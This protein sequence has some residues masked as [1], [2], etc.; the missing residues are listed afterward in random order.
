MSDQITLDDLDIIWMEDGLPMFYGDRDDIFDVVES[1]G[2]NIY[3]VLSNHTKLLPTSSNS[4]STTPADKSAPPPTKTSLTL[5][6]VV[7]NFVGRSVSISDAP[8]P[9]SEFLSVEESC[10]YNMPAIPHLLIEKLDQFFRLVDAQHGTESIVMLTYDLNKQ[11]PEGWG[12]LVPDQTNT[13]VH[14][15]YDPH[16][17]AE[18]KPDH[19]MIVGS[20]HSHPGM[21][22]YASGTDH[23]DQ[24]DFDGI[25]ITFGW[26]KSVNN[27]AT[28]YHIE[29]QMAGQAYTLK[30]ED[31]FEDYIIDKAP[32]PQVVEWSAKVK[33][34]LPPSMGGHHPTTLGQVPQA[35][36]KKAFTEPGTKYS[37]F[38]NKDYVQYPKHILDIIDDSS[39]DK[40]SIIICEANYAQERD[41]YVCPGCTSSIPSTIVFL[42]NS[43]DVCDLPLCEPDQSADQIV[44]DMI[45]YCSE[46][47]IS[48]DRALYLFTYDNSNS[49]MFLRLTPT[50][51]EEYDEGY[52]AHF[53]DSPKDDDIIPYYEITVCCSKSY[54]SCNCAIKVMQTDIMEFDSFMGKQNVYQLDSK[55]ESCY[56]FYDSS[57]PAYRN[58]V[59]DFFN[60]TTKP[61]PEQYH[62]LIDGEG[63]SVYKKYDNFISEDVY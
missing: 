52:P 16:S 48:L 30:P 31:V 49:P 51:L 43:C 15:N 59:L 7:N 1:F 27:G 3:Y 44:Y 40:D 17:I 47:S 22:A 53:A 56:H 58:L 9:S 18:I 32:D 19:I 39:I 57:C 20:V 36:Q 5:F 26:Q 24:A 55:C 25:H 62:S 54:K 61:T 35:Q 41:F 50:T 45:K 11:G 8:L 60:S 37:S 6:K 34:A 28:Q 4:K 29:L 33:K 38:L 21:A 63:C 42:D 23:A 10:H 14:C 2:F 13:S 46:R 12:I